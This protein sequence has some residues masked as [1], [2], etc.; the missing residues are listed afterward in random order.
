LQIHGFSAAKH[1]DYPQVILNSNQIASSAELNRL[2]DA[3]SAAGL[4]VGI[5]VADCWKDLCG[6]TNVQLSSME[7]GV[8]IHMELAD[9]VRNKN[10]VLLNA[11]TTMDLLP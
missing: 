8:F 11:I 3:F 1:P 5:C 4:Q 7:Q 10:K 2:A 9:T 6:R